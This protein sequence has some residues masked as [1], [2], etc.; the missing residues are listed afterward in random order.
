MDLIELPDEIIHSIFCYV[1]SSPSLIGP[2]ICHVLRPL[3]KQWR[4]EVDGK[5]DLWELAVHDLSCDCYG[6]SE[7]ATVAEGRPSKRARTAQ[8]SP[9]RR[10]GRL[11][12]ATPKEQYI[13]AYNLL[14]SRNESALLELQEHAHSSKKPLSLSILKRIVKT[15]EP[16]AIN[17][18]AR[19]GGS[20]LVEV[21][22]ARH[23]QESVI[24]R[25][26]KLLIGEHGASPNLASA[27]VGLGSSS[28]I[29]AVY[30]EASAASGEVG[31]CL[32]SS[33]GK[34]LYPLIIAAARGMPSVVKYLLEA[35]ADPNLRGSSRFRLF[36]NPRKTVKGDELTAL[37]FAV[38]MRDN[39]VENNVR[40][41]D[42]R[43]LQKVITFLE[44]ECDAGAK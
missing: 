35:G 30:D 29:S 11:R 26:I 33:T 25:C 38:K 15:Y 16:I 9:P 10:S 32:S 17:R 3:S 23:V 43:G 41:S 13:H 14:M 34:E 20:F 40:R 39:E 22:R 36:S 6:G 7:D 27:E 21:C 31:R 2:C 37:E 12:P 19:T 18:R 5:R 1:A 4:R 28:T 8:S 44:Q 24:L 42:L